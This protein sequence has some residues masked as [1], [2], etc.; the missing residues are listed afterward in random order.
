[1]ME[2]HINTF[3]GHMDTDSNERD[4]RP[5]DYIDAIGLRRSGTAL[6]AVN[7]T[8]KLSYTPPG[9]A[10]QNEYLGFTEDKFK[11]TGIIFLKNDTADRIIRYWPEEGRFDEMMVWPG[12][13]LSNL[14]HSAVVIDGKYLSFTD[15]SSDKG[16]ITGNP[17]RWIDMDLASLYQKVMTYELHTNNADLTGDYFFA[18]TDFAGTPLSTTSITI[19]ADPFATQLQDLADSIDA[20]PNIIAERC[21]NY[22]KITMAAT[23]RLLALTTLTDALLVGTNHYPTTMAERYISLIRPMPRNAPVPTYYNDPAITENKVFGFSF[24]F[25]YRYIYYDGYKS[26]WSPISCVP[27]N[28]TNAGGTLDATINNEGYNAIRLDITDPTMSSAGHRTFVVKME[29]AV[30]IDKGLWRSVDVLPVP[31]FGTTDLTYT[32]LNSA[33]YGIVASDEIASADAQAL[34][35]QEFVPKVCG[36]MELVSDDHSNAVLTLSACLEGDAAIDCTDAII[37]GTDTLASNPPTSTVD[38]TQVG[39]KLKN[40]GAYD[41]YVLYEDDY[42]RQWPAAKVGRLSIPWGSSPR[43][44]HIP[45]ITLNHLPPER[46][47]KWRFAISEN[48]NQATYI[49]F[50]LCNITPIVTYWVEEDDGTFTS[51]TYATGD[52]DYVSVNLGRLPDLES[53]VNVLFEALNRN[54]LVETGDRIHF[55][56]SEATP[57]TFDHRIV[58][59]NLNNPN[60]GSGDQYYVFFKWDSAQPN[61]T[62]GSG[63][64]VVAEIYRQRTTDSLIIYEFPE[65]YEVD[66]AG[67]PT[68]NHG[69]AEE[70]LFGDAWARKVVVDALNN[71][72]QRTLRIEHFNL[73]QDKIIKD[74]DHGRAVA[75]DPD[76]REVFDYNKVRASG[77]FVPNTFTNGLPSFKGTDYVRV[78]R[79]IGSIQRSVFLKSILLQVGQHGSHPIYVGSGQVLDFRGGALLGKAQELL[80]VAPDI[81]PYGT[82]DTLSVVSN[83]KHIYGWDGYLG[84]PWSYSVGGGQEDIS[85]GNKNLFQ[86]ISESNFPQRANVRVR[87]GINQLHEEYMLTFRPTGVGYNNTLCYNY[88]SGGWTG[89]MPFVPECY[90]H[91]GLESFVM[92]IVSVYQLDKGVYGTFLDSSEDIEIEFVANPVPLSPK[93]F[94]FFDQFFSSLFR[95]TSLSI[96][97]STPNGML[98][99]IVAGRWEKKEGHWFASVPGDLNDTDPRFT[100]AIQ[101]LENGR[102]MRGGAMKIRMRLEDNTKPAILRSFVTNYTK[103]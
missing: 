89:R 60:T 24:Q 35:N 33:I 82:H 53:D 11:K 32:F 47:T 7:G 83:G 43:D 68:R 3:T 50:P 5:E 54:V 80:T 17:P 44:R 49:Q 75:E 42:G 86:S 41:I 96:T 6:E 73:Y 20:S 27:S 22:I 61:Y 1:M 81:L 78:K 58:G 56:S 95:A 84:V 51:T 40:G 100:T 62:I 13:N 85:K 45:E 37:T 55:W 71:T 64:A 88:G 72:E 10:L 38:Q 15:G 12:L 92:N 29:V 98:S 8:L 46:A 91:I 30:S 94:V 14:V 76:Y 59:Y 102:K 21:G 23:D 74:T 36:S 79:E 31:D 28:F 77:L 48:L 57:I 101:R 4:V 93:L 18:V 87:G 16:L 70:V 52:A 9:N 69:G 19:G 99:R 25:R 34:G 65:T 26:K 67:L 63:V 66:G 39:R 2:K 90:G 103:S 97:D